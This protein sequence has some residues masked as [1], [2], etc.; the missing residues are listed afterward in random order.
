MNTHLESTASIKYLS[1]LFFLSG[2]T[3]TIALSVKPMPVAFYAI[4]LVACSIL[5]GMIAFKYRIIEKVLKSTSKIGVLLSILL[6]IAFVVEQYNGLVANIERL[7]VLHIQANSSL[8][9]YAS[10]ITAFWSYKLFFLV[11]VFAFSAYS[12]CC[13]LICVYS[14]VKDPILSFFKNLETHERIFLITVSLLAATAILIVFHATNAFYMPFSEG[15]EINF[16]VIYTSDAGILLRRD[17]YINPASGENDLRQPLFG[18]FAM[19]F[20]LLAKLISYIILS[21]SSYPLISNILQVTLLIISLILFSRMLEVS[22]TSKIYFLITATACF[23]FLLFSLNMEQYIFAVFWTTL[24][25]YNSYK[26]RQVSIPL[27]VAAAGSILTSCVLVPFLLILNKEVK[28]GM[29]KC[30]KMSVLFLGIFIC[31]GM[32]NVIYR[33]KTLFTE[34]FKY[35]EADHGFIGKC[36]QFTGFI[37]SCFFAPCSEVVSTTYTSYQLCASHSFN[38]IGITILA[39]CIVSV[40]LHRDRYIAKISGYWIGFAFLLICVLGWGTSENGT[41]LYSLYFYWAFLIPITLLIEKAFTKTK[42]IGHLLF[43]ILIASLI[44]LNI[45]GGFDLINFGITYYPVV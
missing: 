19:P 26:T 29:R 12:L 42:F 40:L 3:L 11:P 37:S 6:S 33:T 16:D 23:P 10:Y 21:P 1:I 34:Y 24:L 22:K 36:H 20:G 38:V 41:I 30:I 31:G 5:W 43:C 27:S 14:G 15:R 7:E 35:T 25:L 32:I 18:I 44:S 17:A 9:P 45:K 13:L 39:L 28:N 2:I 4:E 8:A